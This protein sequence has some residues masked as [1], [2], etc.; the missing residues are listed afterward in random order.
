MDREELGKVAYFAAARIYAE[1]DPDEGYDHPDWDGL[2]LIDDKAKQAHIDAAEAVV[3]HVEPH[4]R[5][6]ERRKVLEELIAEAGS[7]VNPDGLYPRLRWAATT[8]WLRL[9]LEP[10]P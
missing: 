7:R 10:T 1:S 5:A 9:H 8:D 2:D 6:D 4:I 3:A